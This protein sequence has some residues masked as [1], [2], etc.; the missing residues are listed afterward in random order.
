[1]HVL[2]C[3]WVFAIKQNPDGSNKYKARFVVGSHRQ[4]EGIDYKETFA[5]VLKY[6]SLRILLAIATFYDFEVHQI[7]FVTAFLNADLE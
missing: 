6:T 3:T 4:K 5:P 2:P 7:D 1:M